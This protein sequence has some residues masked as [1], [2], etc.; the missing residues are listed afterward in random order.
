MSDPV[1]LWRANRTWGHVVFQRIAAALDSPHF[2]LRAFTMAGKSLGVALTLDDLRAVS[3][4][5]DAELAED[6]RH[7]GH[8]R[9][10]RKA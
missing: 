8:P 7:N 4:V 5:I 6:N 3:R 9:H 10:R 2:E 1:V